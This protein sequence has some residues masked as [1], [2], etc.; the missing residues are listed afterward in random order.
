MSKE[1]NGFSFCTK[2]DLTILLGLKARNIEGLLRAIRE[3]P[4]ASIYYHT[5][6]FLQ[7]HN[8]LSPEP[9]NDFAY[10]VSDVLGDDALG[11]Q[12]SS[13]DIVQYESISELRDKFVRI[14]EDYLQTTDRRV[15]CPSGDEFHFMA[16]RTFVF[17]TP[18][19]AHTLTEL[20]D[21]LTRVSINSLYYHIF[22][23]KLRLK[24]GENDFSRWF[25]DRGM[26]ELADE[27]KRLDPYRHTLE[28]LRR[29]I[30]VLTK[31]YDS[32]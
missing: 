28:G 1:T 11:E 3:V 22:D 21:I 5:H 13:V 4:D 6:H 26:N 10:W 27:V 29:R 16:S 8:Y 9:P 30:M 17:R 15:D 32:H 7:Q 18:Y 12:L 14:L 24:Q 25:R 31:R 2:L 20:R 19:C 23:A